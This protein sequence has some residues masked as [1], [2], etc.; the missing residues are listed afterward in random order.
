MLAQSKWIRSLETR[1]GVRLRI[2]PAAADD[3]EDILRFLRS[4]SSA[5]LRFRFLSAVKPS[6]ALA[7]MLADVDHRN[8]E[9]LVAIDEMN[10]AIAATA[11][12]ARGSDPDCAEVA[13]LV[14]SDLKNHGIGWEMLEQ[15]CDYAR[16]RGF[17]RV[18][19]LE[20]STNQRAISLEHE[21]GFA[22]HFYPND[23]E[24]TV[25][26]RNLA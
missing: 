25:L 6:E 2:R 1:S 19:C 9:D 8:S 23:A 18:E 17:K 4:V 10:G 24:L 16:A 12:I 15:A 5:D 22:S 26:T 21:Q 11:M 3:W 7:R 14:R 13:V 20:A